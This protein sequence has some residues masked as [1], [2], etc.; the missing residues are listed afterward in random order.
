MYKRGECRIAKGDRS[1]QERKGGPTMEKSREQSNAEVPDNLVWKGCST[2]GGA[3]SC[4]CPHCK[5]KNSLEAIS[6]ASGDVHNREGITGTGKKITWG[7]KI[8]G[9]GCSFAIAVAIGIILT[10]VVGER[11]TWILFVMLAAFLVLR[12][13]LVPA[14]MEELPVWAV[15]CQSCKNRIF[16]ATNGKQAAIGEPVQK[17]S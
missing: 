11:T 5:E 9:L 6:F 8:Q 16:L 10:A 4:Q 2:E 3:I 17:S 13:I 7:R 14:F 12:R 15:E 1:F